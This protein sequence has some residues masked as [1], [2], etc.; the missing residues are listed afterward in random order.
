MTGLSPTRRRFLLSATIGTAAGVVPVSEDSSPAHA[1]RAA[2]RDQQELNDFLALSRELTGVQK[3]NSDLGAQY[4]RRFKETFGSEA[5]TEILKQY[6]TILG[7]IPSSNERLKAIKQKII[8]A[9]YIGAAAEQII[10]I[11]YLSA[12]FLPNPKDP[13]VREQDEPGGT[14]REPDA[15]DE[16]RG[17]T[18]QFG[19]LEQYEK[20]LIWEVI[21]AHPPMTPGPYK[22]HWKDKPT[23]P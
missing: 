17:G 15:D 2:S 21:G 6:R 10:Y 4:L 22:F 11:W 23:L 5:L 9:E 14:S 16:L 1:Q 19:T 20:G 18:W 13:E 8:D 3:L 7:S 12:F